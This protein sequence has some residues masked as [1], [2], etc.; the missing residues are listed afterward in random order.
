MKDNSKADVSNT[1]EFDR[2]YREMVKAMEEKIS[3]RYKHSEVKDLAAKVLKIK[4]EIAIPDNCEV[5]DDN[6]NVISTSKIIIREKKK[7]V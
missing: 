4:E 6:G 2:M 5:W 7:E 3:T 1:E